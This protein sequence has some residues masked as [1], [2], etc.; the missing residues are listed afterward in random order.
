MVL[1][2]LA[3]IN[4]TFF[5]HFRL[6]KKFKNMESREDS[7]QEIDVTVEAVDNT[8]DVDSTEAVD[9]NETVNNVPPRKKLK[10]QVSIGPHK[11]RVL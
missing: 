11:W 7:H 5:F 4:Q 9:S 3:M 1:V 6:K 2:E 8:E 10:K